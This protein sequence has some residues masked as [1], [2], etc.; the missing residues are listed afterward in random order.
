MGIGSGSL[1]CGLGELVTATQL[2]EVRLMGR[3]HPPSR[4]GLGGARVRVRLMRGVWVLG[5]ECI[6]RSGSEEESRA[7]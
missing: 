5:L 3:P 7:S 6:R 2:K 1:G 4:D